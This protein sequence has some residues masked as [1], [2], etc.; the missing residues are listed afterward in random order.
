MARRNQRQYHFEYIYIIYMGRTRKRNIESCL[1]HAMGPSQE[2]NSRPL[3]TYKSRI[4]SHDTHKR[5]EKGGIN[6]NINKE[7]AKKGKMT[8]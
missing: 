5:R 4:L 8:R 1:Q 2:V 6:I 3:P 7:K